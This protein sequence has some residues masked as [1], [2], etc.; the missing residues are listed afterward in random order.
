MP[1]GA[2]H[3]T[4]DRKKLAYIHIVK[5]ELGLSDKEYRDT[6]QRQAGVRSAKDLDD[7]KFRKLVNFLVRS[8]RYKINKGGL[9]IKQKYF[10][11]HMAEEIGWDADHLRNF[12]RKYYHVDRLDLLSRK[13]AAKAIESLKNIKA[14]SS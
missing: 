1:S 8:G 13:Q 11:K 9:T 3:M 10:I 7:E 6:L 5:K 4:I 2:E 12:I 14:R